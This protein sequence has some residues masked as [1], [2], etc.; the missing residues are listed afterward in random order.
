MNLLPIFVNLSGRRGL[1]VGAGSVALDKLSSLLSTGVLLRVVAPHADPQIHALAADGMLEWI[2]RVFQPSDLDGV[3]LAIAATDDPQVNAAVYQ[4]AL[5][6]NIPCNSVDDIP[7]CDFFFGSVVRRGALQIAISTSGESPAVA[8]RLRREID[9]QLPADLGPWLAQLGELR[10]EVLATHPRGEARKALLHQL[11]HLPLCDSATC[12]TRQLARAPLA[13]SDPSPNS[14]P[15]PEPASARAF[16]VGAGPGDPDLLTVKAVRLLQSAQVVLHDDLVP[17]AILRLVPST[18]EIVNVGKRCGTKTI[19]QDEINAL[20]VAHIRAGRS[21]VRLKSGDP[22]LFGRASEEMAAL[23]EANVLFE[24]VPGISA[25]F[26]AAASLGVSLTSRTAASNV[27]FSTGHHAQ[28]HNH[29]PLPEKEDLTRVVYM[30]GRD[31]TLFAL[32]WL[33]EGLPPDLPCALVSRAAQPDEQIH[34]TTLENL[35]TA[36]TA[37]APSLLLA[38]WALRERANTPVTVGSA[39]IATTA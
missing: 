20:M 11:A 28:S 26:A 13:L 30:P 18:A 24:V 6:R 17:V 19:T 15:N 10:R 16:L 7:N 4:A 1:L 9:A 23:A 2:P 14:S 5:E 27:L 31:L 25:A 39:A 33:Q 37:Q 12:P 21:V 29:A 8:Q 22:L 38:G 32:Q 34:H 3:F 35:G 36:P